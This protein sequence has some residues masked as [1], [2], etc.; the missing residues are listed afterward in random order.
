ME[1][2]G[3]LR[4]PV[5]GFPQKIEQ[6]GL[7]TLSN[8]G[9]LSPMSEEDYWRKYRADHPLAKP[10]YFT[11]KSGSRITPT[12]DGA[13]IAKF[14]GVLV[15]IALVIGVCVATYHQALEESPYHD[16]RSCLADKGCAEDFTEWLDCTARYETGC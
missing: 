1:Q 14:I 13:Y 6:D 7:D 15:G 12:G 8:P 4:H 9:K 5:V 11:P 10:R 2:A 16:T 3:G